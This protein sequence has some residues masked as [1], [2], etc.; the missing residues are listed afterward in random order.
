MKLLDAVNLIM[1]KLGER[2]VTSLAVKHPTLAVLL[3]IIEQTR[4]TTLLRGWWFNKYAYTAYPDSD[5]RIVL[6]TDTLSFVPAE[7]DTAVVRGNTLFNPVTM[8]D[9]FDGPVKGIIIQ[10]VSFDVMP[11]SAAYYVF[12][13][14]M[15]EAFATDIGVT[16]ELSVWQSK[17]GQGWS[18]LTMEHLRQVKYSTKQHSSWAKLIRAMR[19]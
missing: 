12:Y 1:P 11:E 19:A 14:A 17:A 16:Q 15:V 10:D 9:V 7:I 8:T 4:K 13:S 6:G 3:P 2:P 5:G 18:D